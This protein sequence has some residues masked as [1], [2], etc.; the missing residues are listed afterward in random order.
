MN[1][2]KTISALAVTLLIGGILGSVGAS[3]YWQRRER[4]KLAT[5]CDSVIIL[6]VQQ[7]ELLDKTDIESSKAELNQRLAAYVLT[8]EEFSSRKDFAGFIARR[9]IFHASSRRNRQDYLIA[10]GIVKEESKI[11]YAPII[12]R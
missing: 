8:A 11:R 2:A 1:S 6:L 10:E 4:E 9:A 12:A 3:T 7:L 5:T